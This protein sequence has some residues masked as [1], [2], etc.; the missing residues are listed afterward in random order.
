MEV[1]VAELSWKELKFKGGCFD[2]SVW[3]GGGIGGAR[4]QGWGTT[5]FVPPNAQGSTSS[6]FRALPSSTSN[7]RSSRFRP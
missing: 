3:G 5:N 4:V 2:A 6:C 1:L 7:L